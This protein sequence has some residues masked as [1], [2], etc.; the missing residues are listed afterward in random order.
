[1]SRFTLAGEVTS[2]TENQVSN[3]STD[4]NVNENPVE[5]NEDLFD[6]SIEQLMEV[7]VGSTATLTESKPRLVPA[8]VTTITAEEI[9]LSGARSL[10]ELL[11]IYVPNLQWWRNHWEP[12]NIGL[13]GILSDRDDKYLLLVNGRV[14]NERT[15]YGAL[16]ER[17]LVLLTDIHHIDIVRGPGS[18][19]YGPGAVSMVINIITYNS[20]TF[21]GTEVTGRLGAVEEFYSAEIKHGQPFESDDGGLFLYAGISNYNGAD[22]YDAPQIFG[23]DFPPTPVGDSPMP[24]DGFPK[25]EPFT[26]W[27]VNDGEA[28]RNLPPLKLYS[29]LLKGNWNIWLRYT[30]GGQQFIWPTGLLARAPYGWTG[31]WALPLEDCTYGYQQATGFIGHNSDL[32]ESTNLDLQFSYDMFDFERRVHTWLLNAHREDKYIGKA[33]IRH[34]F[35]DQHKVAIGTEILHGEYGF[36][37]PGWPEEDNPLGFGRWSTNMYSGFGEYQWTIN[38]QWTTFLGARVDDHTYTN[39]LF[40]PRAALIH[41]PNEKD[42]YKLMWA[43]SVRANYEEELK[44]EAIHDSRPEKLDS[45]EFRY[46]RRQNKNLDLAASVFSHYNLEL[47]GWS[48]AAEAQTVVGT[49]KEWGIELEATYHT[50]RTR[51]SISHGYTKLQEFELADPNMVVSDP[52]IQFSAEPYGYGDDLQRWANHITK[53]TARHKINDKW[54]ADGSL[55]VYWGFPGLKDYAKYNAANSGFPLRWERAYRASC[56]LNLGLKYQHS[57]RLS[58]Q[59]NGYNL[60]GIFNKDFNK[61]TYGGEGYTDFRSHAAAVGV[62]A[63]YRTK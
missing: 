3:N 12:D 54:T 7:E 32:N 59:V 41:T 26:P 56:F 13:R 20:T 17:D 18:A 35:N 51:L 19:L 38:D 30:R 11:D 55:R 2:S 61:R 22:K 9:Q 21:E 50:D 62:Y 14:M 10:F 45:L 6:L 5:D 24:Q 8:A 37:S 63:V 57:D 36:N 42:T 46:E 29:E 23:F 58:F 15:H 31:S 16:S 39:A 25:G 60:L 44:R 1:L 34:N 48:N 49:L 28:H 33:T 47:I 53:I 43:R 40:S 52:F 4:A 27:S